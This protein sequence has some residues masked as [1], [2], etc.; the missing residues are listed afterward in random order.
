MT[1]NITADQIRPGDRLFLTF[2]DGT[3]RVVTASRTATL[4]KRS[5]RVLVTFDHN[6]QRGLVW[7]SGKD[8]AVLHRA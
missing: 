4:Y 7:L 8:I 5:Y 6:P 2:Q 1:S 3:R